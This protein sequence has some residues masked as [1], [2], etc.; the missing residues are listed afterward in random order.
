MCIVASALKTLWVLRAIN[1][2]Q[3]ITAEGRLMALFPLEPQYACAI[4]ASADYHCTSEI[5]DIVS[6]LSASS[7]LFVDISEHRDAVADARRKFRH[8]SGDHMTI[9]NAFRAYRE[10]ARAENKH[11][12]RDW[13]R[14]H[15]LNERTFI[16]ARDIREQLAMTCKQAGISSSSSANGKEDPIISSLGHGLVANSALLQPDGSYKQTIGQVVSRVFVN[17]VLSEASF[18]GGENS[19]QF[20]AS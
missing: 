2:G 19:S 4:V 7:K 1:D 8:Q 18:L 20:F 5:L 6:I 3:S 10:I 16:E 17:L 11:G 14:R 15:F 9:L 12:R 13:C